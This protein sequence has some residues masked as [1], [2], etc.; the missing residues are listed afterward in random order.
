[1]NDLILKAKAFATKAHGDINQKRKYTGEPYIVHPASVANRVS[2]ITENANQICA[3]WLHDTV[4]DTEA[5]IEDIEREFGKDIMILVEMLT[6]V[7]RP[8][9]GNRKIRKEMDRQHSKL[10][11]PEAKTVKLADLNDNA[12]SIIKDGK[13]FA[14]V[15]MSE[16]ELLL[17]VLKEGD[18]RLYSEAREIVNTYKASRGKR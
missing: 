10:A 15:F 4:E 2:K 17:D 8:D 18:E 11:S 13:S 1:M 14:P 3:A 5:T 7:S 12:Y 9:D 6:D 16:M